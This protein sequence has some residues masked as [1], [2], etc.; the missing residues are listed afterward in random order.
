LCRVLSQHSLTLNATVRELEA[1]SVSNCT[2]SVGDMQT[3]YCI[4]AEAVNL[5]TADNISF[6]SNDSWSH[7][8]DAWTDDPGSAAE[9]RAT[10]AVYLIVRHYVY[11]KII[12]GI[13]L[14]G[15]VGN[16][17]SLVLG[18][19]CKPQMS[20]LDRHIRERLENYNSQNSRLQTVR[21]TVETTESTSCHHW[22]DAESF[23]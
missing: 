3:L 21:L 2:A 5:S 16:L 6:V 8:T 17:S 4:D 9:R 23:R 12:P 18:V 15:I 10:E 11:Q 22:T 7:E 13:M 14:I 20:S 19:R 1:Y